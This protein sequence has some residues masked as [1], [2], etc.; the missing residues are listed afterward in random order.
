MT[1]RMLNYCRLSFYNHVANIAIVVI[2]THSAQIALSK[3]YLLKHMHEMVEI[4][5]FTRRN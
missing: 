1:S 4:F 5:V 2:F 3:I